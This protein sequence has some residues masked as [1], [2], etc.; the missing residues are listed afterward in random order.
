MEPLPAVTLQVNCVPLVIN[1]ILLHEID[2]NDM[3]TLC[4]LLPNPLPVTVTVPPDVGGEVTVLTKGVLEV[5]TC[6]N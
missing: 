4:A 3:L 5:K 2:P 1:W 6:Q